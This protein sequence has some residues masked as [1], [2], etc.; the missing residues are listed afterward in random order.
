MKRRKKINIFTIKTI[1]LI[2]I[3][4][5]TFSSLFLTGC[6]NGNLKNS[7]KPHTKNKVTEEKQTQINLQQTDISEINVSEIEAVQGV[8]TRVVDGDT[9]ELKS[10]QVVRFINMNTPESTNKIEKYGKEASQFTKRMLNGKT[11]WLTKDISETDQYGR[12]L[13]FVWLKKPTNLSEKEFR[14]NCF[15]AILVLRGYAMSY[16]YKPDISYS[17]YFRKFDREA[18]EKK[19]GLWQFGEN[20]TTKGDYSSEN[21]ANYD[22]NTNLGIP[23]EQALDSTTYF[24]P[25]GKS[26]HK[27]K[28]CPTLSRSKTI[29]SGTL[30]EAINKGHQDPC[31]FCY[32]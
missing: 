20:G 23:K 3:L 14:A 4:S 2:Y 29:L 5:I 10:G 16:S 6:D 24:T 25:S 31:D 13:R 9:I 19:L 15:N 22:I 26:Y 28:N 11:V 7:S 8:V 21:K 27:F 30:T 17:N 12:L 18:F 1:I 32:K